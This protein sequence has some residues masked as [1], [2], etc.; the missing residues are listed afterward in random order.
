M[1]EFNQKEIA[2]LLFVIQD[3][4]TKNVDEI[5]TRDNILDKLRR[6]VKYD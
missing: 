1:I 4:W 5:E 2:L 3:F 6:E